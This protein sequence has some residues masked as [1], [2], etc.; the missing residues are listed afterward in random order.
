M[1]SHLF[2]GISDEI[3]VFGHGS[4]QIRFSHQRRLNKGADALLPPAGSGQQLAHKAMG[5]ESGD[6]GVRHRAN[7]KY[8]NILLT[9]QHI[10]GHIGRNGQLP[11]HIIAVN[12][13]G[14]IGLGIAK[15]LC[16]LQNCREGHRG[17]MHGIHNKVGGAI[18]NAT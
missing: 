12:V 15:L 5:L 13:G 7:T 1:A 16:L 3:E 11:A 6:V 10:E 4:L 17:G 8:G 2:S 18:H 14:G 9:Q